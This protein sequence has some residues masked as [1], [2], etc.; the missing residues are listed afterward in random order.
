MGEVVLRPDLPQPMGGVVLRPDSPRPMS[1]L[2]LRPDSGAMHWANSPLASHSDAVVQHPP[3]K[4]IEKSVQEISCL[5]YS[6]LK[7]K[8]YNP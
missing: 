6:S 5:I 3:W 8:N 7:K 4:G 1:G 2:V